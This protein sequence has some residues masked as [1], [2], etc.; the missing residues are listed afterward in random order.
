VQLAD[1]ADG[2][3]G[4]ALDGEAESDLSGFSVSGGADINGDGLDDVI[5]GAQSADPGGLDRSGRSY[6]VFGKAETDRVSL[7]DVAT[8]SGGFAI[9]GE[10]DYGRAGWSVS[11]T[12][13]AD[14]DGTADVVVGAPRVTP[15]AL[16]EAG[17]AYVVRGKEDTD[18]VMLADVAL[19]TGGFAMDGEAAWTYAG[20]TVSGAGDVNGDGLGDL[21]VSAPW[22]PYGGQSY[23]GRAYVVFGKADTTAVSLADV[24]T[25]TGGFL[26]AGEAEDG[27]S[28]IALS[29]AGDVDG[30]GLDDVIVGAPWVGP[31]DD[32]SGRSYVVFG[33][34]NTDG[35]LLA[36]V[37][38]GYGGF[39]IHGE[40][41]SDYSGEA[42][43]GAGDVNGDGLADVIVGAHQADPN[44]AE[45]SGR[46]YV[47]FGKDNSDAVSLADVAQGTGGFALD[48]EAESDESGFSVSGAGDVD[49][50]GHSDI[51]V[52]APGGAANGADSGRTY[53]VFGKAETDLVSLADVAQG[54][55]GFVLDGE[56]EG[57]LSG[58]S[59][60]GGG[61]V[62]GDGHADLVVGA[63]QA[64]P[65][66]VDSSGRTY[67]VFG[68]AC[69]D[70]GG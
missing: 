41:A 18:P 69:S 39:A 6:V 44:G 40:A 31:G 56:A 46:T 5:V 54:I 1:V 68:F 52:G 23:A 14:G 12:S 13:D 3:G 24:T 61:D 63:H 2:T 30:D 4:F 34:D 50:D 32:R 35:V 43:S 15:N 8:G 20:W 48:G 38:Q 49:G 65:N 33:K 51:V 55:G 21:L 36:D 57:D 53:V 16:E 25:G 27:N 45:S 64:D 28:G 29:G 26:I 60:S 22:A 17:R 7:A 67:V 10:A 37:S 58:F 70:A 19:G 42:V 11:A 59:V 66:S 47:V 9:D 62:N